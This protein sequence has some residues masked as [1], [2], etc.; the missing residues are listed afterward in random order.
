[1]AKKLNDLVHE[2][3]ES[4]TYITFFYGELHKQTG[5]FF[6]INAGHFPPIIL[7][8]KGNVKRL[9]TCGFCLGM[10]P[11]VDYE[12]KELQLEEEDIA[13]MFTDG[14]TECRNKVDEEYS[15]EKLIEVLKNSR[16]LSSEKL[17]DKIFDD[18][19]AYTGETEQMDDM[20]LVIV[21]RISL[22]IFYRQ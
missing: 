12:V 14:I 19:N 4:N 15:E 8:K 1:M 13:L 18:V 5:E 7:D 3:T 10:F 16:K 17:C 21:K 9:G 22:Y 11:V 6:Y 2:T 20:T